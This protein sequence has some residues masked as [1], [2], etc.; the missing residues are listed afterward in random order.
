M[1]TEILDTLLKNINILNSRMVEQKFQVEGY[2][3][4]LKD[5]VAE[6]AKVKQQVEAQGEAEKI[7]ASERDKKLAEKRAKRAKK[8]AESNDK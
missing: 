3:L 5:V 8:T 7:R 2:L 1:N 6:M 4:A